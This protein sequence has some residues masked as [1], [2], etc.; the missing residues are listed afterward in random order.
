MLYHVQELEQLESL[1]QEVA[2][3]KQQN[4]DS[5]AAVDALQQQVVQLHQQ[6][7][8]AGVEVEQLRQQ[9]TA[10]QAAQAAAT[11][12]VGWGEGNA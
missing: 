6:N 2:H 8:D 7:I 4:S 9:L 3:L 12:Q 5:A 11:D 10:A 1:Q